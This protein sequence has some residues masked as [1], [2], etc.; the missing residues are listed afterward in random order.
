MK[1]YIALCCD[2][3]T[4]PEVF[5]STTLRVAVRHAKTFVEENAR[6]PEGIREVHYDSYEYFCSYS[7]EEY[8]Y[9]CVKEVELY[10][11]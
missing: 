8:D 10:E 6:F 1:I 9:V 7:S 2:R 11:S 5:A 4:D 3:Q